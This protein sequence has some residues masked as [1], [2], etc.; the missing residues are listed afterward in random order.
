MLGTIHVLGVNS[1]HVRPLVVV[2]NI[3]GSAAGMD[4]IVPLIKTIAQQV[5]SVKIEGIFLTSFDIF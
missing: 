5:Y 3:T 4:Y 2:L 1:L